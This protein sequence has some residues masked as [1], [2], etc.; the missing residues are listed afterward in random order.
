MAA[1]DFVD[2][3]LA[4]GIRRSLVRRHRQVLDGLSPSDG[5][6]Q[7]TWK[8]GSARVIAN[9]LDVLG[10]ENVLVTLE[11]GNRIQFLVVIDSDKGVGFACMHELRKKGLREDK[12]HELEI[13]VPIGITAHFRER[14]IQIPASLNP[15][16]ASLL[17]SLYS[18]VR[19]RF[20]AALDMNG[21][22][23]PHWHDVEGRFA[24]AN[25]SLLMFGDVGPT[26]DLICKT[27]IR[28]DRLERR[29]EVVWIEAINTPG[30]FITFR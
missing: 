25:S 22:I 27:V 18:A 21:E 23:Y 26:S 5:N 6:R 11:T 2:E 13:Y 12:R 30:G 28:R 8:K 15:G 14:L 1:D 10:P 16:M 29:N 24:F 9:F 17:F 7:S 4:K 20:T 3:S 19:S